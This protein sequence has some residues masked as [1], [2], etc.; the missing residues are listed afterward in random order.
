MNDLRGRITITKSTMKNF[1]WS[2]MEHFKLE[3][4]AMLYRAYGWQSKYISAG[5]YAMKEDDVMCTFLWD[6]GNYA[7][8]KQYLQALHDDGY[9]VAGFTPQQN[10]R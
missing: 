8:S 5:W 6:C 1:K 4:E 3:L 2:I 7:H 9:C 10:K